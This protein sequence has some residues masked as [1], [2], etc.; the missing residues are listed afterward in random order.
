MNELLTSVVLLYN[1]NGSLLSTIKTYLP[2]VQGQL[3]FIYLI[4]F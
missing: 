2:F 1:N 4:Y 3:Q